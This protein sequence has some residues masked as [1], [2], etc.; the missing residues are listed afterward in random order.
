MRTNKGFTLFIG[1]V[2][3][4]ILTTITLGQNPPLNHFNPY[5]HEGNPYLPMNIFLVAASFNGVNMAEGDFTLKSDSEVYKKI[6]GFQRLPFHKMGLFRDTWRREL[7]K[8]VGF[9]EKNK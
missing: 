7:P 4:L 9:A 2:L 5:P 3:T 8:R 1:V 6:P